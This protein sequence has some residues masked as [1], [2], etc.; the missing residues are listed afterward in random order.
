MV[1][2]MSWPGYAGKINHILP[3]TFW[4]PSNMFGFD[5][6]CEQGRTCQWCTGIAQASFDAQCRNIMHS[7]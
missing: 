5:S 4:S 2:Q 3:K 1:K 7:A 6:G